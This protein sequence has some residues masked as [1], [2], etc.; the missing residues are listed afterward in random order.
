M[1]R[2][3]VLFLVFWRKKYWAV[4]QQY[5]MRSRKARCPFCL[6]VRYLLIHVCT[7]VCSERASE[8]AFVLPLVLYGAWRFR[9]PRFGFYADGGFFP[10]SIVARLLIRSE[11]YINICCRRSPVVQAVFRFPPPSLPIF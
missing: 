1:C 6:F 8:R 2:P 4:G 9:W 10:P 11:N 7:C 5:N 3:A